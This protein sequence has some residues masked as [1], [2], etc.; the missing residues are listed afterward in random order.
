MKGVIHR[1]LKPANVALVEE[2][3]QVVCKLLDFGLAKLPTPRA[4]SRP[5]AMIGAP[6]YA[7]PEQA[8]GS[9]LDLRSDI[10]SLGIILY[11]ML[12]GRRPFDGADPATLL[13]QHLQATPPSLAAARQAAGQTEPAPE[14]LEGLVM[15]CL[16]KAPA[17]RPVSVRRVAADLRGLRDGTLDNVTGR[18]LLDSIAPR[19]SS[20]PPPPEP[21]AAPAVAPAVTPAPAA[22]VPTFEPVIDEAALAG[23]R[24][25]QRGFVVLILAV[26][27]L[28]VGLGLAAWAFGLI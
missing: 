26:I 12:A 15:K 9:P 3:G 21:A 18:A 14:L 19:I 10:Y 16:A 7:S 24:Q 5:G 4:V 20:I 6:H 22:P 25:E 11:E 17:D 27:F 28:G 8:T 13:E 2:G 23:E 1:D